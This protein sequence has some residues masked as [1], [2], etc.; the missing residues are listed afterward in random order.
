MNAARVEAWAWQVIER[1]TAGEPIEDSRVEC[2]RIWISEHWEVARQLA[3]HANAARGDMLLWLIGVD[4][5]DGVVGVPH[6]EVSSWY[7]QVLSQFAEQAAPAMQRVVISDSGKTFVA[8]LF[9]T[10]RAPYVVNL[11]RGG[12]DVPGGG[13]VTREVPWREANSTRTATHADLIR[14]LVPLQR[15]PD[16]EVLDGTLTM[17]ESGQQSSTSWT[18]SLNIYVMPQLPDQLTIPFHHCQATLTI[19]DCCD[20]LPPSAFSMG[21]LYPHWG[22]PAQRHEAPARPQPLS[23]TISGTGSEVH[24]TGSGLIKVSATW[25]IS[26]LL[27]RFIDEP[28]R[29]SL[30]LRPVHTDFALVVDVALHSVPRDPPNAPQ[31]WKTP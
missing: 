2:K 15:R 20:D 27:D 30:R 7:D 11:P 14:I 5:E 22:G 12:R 21:P 8:L 3:G 25:Q 13:R 23:D 24:I 31:T 26:R 28:A 17:L 18:L 1:I 10:D 9:E 29:V 16:V 19:P 6:E 4:E